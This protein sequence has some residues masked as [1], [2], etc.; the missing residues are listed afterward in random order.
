M[1]IH[2]FIRPIQKLFGSFKYEN[3]KSQ[4]GP[5]EGKAAQYLTCDTA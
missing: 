3:S 1:E 5:L 2:H 4:E